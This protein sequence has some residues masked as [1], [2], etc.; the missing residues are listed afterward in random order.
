MLS[1]SVQG[2]QIQKP[3]EKIQM[4]DLPNSIKIAKDATHPSSQ[5]QSIYLLIS[6]V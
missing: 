6:P 4:L 2:A 3:N 5:S 1:L